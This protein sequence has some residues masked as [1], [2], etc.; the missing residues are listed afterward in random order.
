MLP[1]KTVDNIPLDWDRSIVRNIVRPRTLECGDAPLVERVG[2][3]IL[4]FN[5]AEE[6]IFGD[7]ELDSDDAE[8]DADLLEVQDLTK[9]DLCRAQCN[10]SLP[11]TADIRDRTTLSVLDTPLDS[12]PEEPTNEPPESLA[13]RSDKLETFLIQRSLHRMVFICRV[14]RSQRDLNRMLR[15]FRQIVAQ[16]LHL[17]CNHPCHSWIFVLTKS[18][19]QSI[20]MP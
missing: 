11:D 19:N 17:Q 18:K 6:E 2:D 8:L 16:G 12:I 20:T 4:F 9:Q 15:S 5:S 3:R 13:L 10:N 1:A 14:Q 7:A